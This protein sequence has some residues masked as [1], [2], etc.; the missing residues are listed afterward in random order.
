[1][2]SRRVFSFNGRSLPSLPGLT[3]GAAS[4]A[5]SEA[6]LVR[7]MRAGQD[8][9]RGSCRN[10]RRCGGSVHGVGCRRDSGRFRFGSVSPA[11]GELTRRENLLIDAPGVNAPTSTIADYAVLGDCHGAA[12]V[13]RNGSIDWCSLGRFDADPIFCRILDAGKGGFL[14]VEATGLQETSRTYAGPTNILQTSMRTHSGTVMLTDL[15]PVGRRSGSTNHDYVSLTAPHALI[16]IIECVEG[17]AQVTVRFRPSADFARNAARLELQKG[18]V[19]TNAG[20]DLRSDLSFT[21]DGDVASTTVDLRQGERRVLVLAPQADD[22]FERVDELVRVTTAFWTEWA[23]Y[24][25]YEGPWREQVLRSAL[26]LKLLTYAPTGAIVAA[27]T[28]SLPEEIGGVRNW[29]YRYC[30]LRD[31]SFTLYALAALGYSGE[32]RR[33]MEFTQL[34]CASSHPRVQIMYGIGGE[35]RLDE[36]ELTHLAGYRDSR[37]VRIGNAAFEQD[38]LDVYGEVLDWAW[39]QKKLGQ[40]FSRASRGFFK[41]LADEI[42]ARWRKPDHGIWEERAEPRHYVIGKLVAWAALDRASLMFRGRR[43]F[44]RERDAIRELILREGV[45]SETGALKE[46]LGTDGVDAALLLAPA[47]GFPLDD[48]CLAATI[49]RVQSRL[50]EGGFLRRYESDDGLPGRDGA[51]LACNF[52]LADALLSLDRV[53]DARAAFE[54]AA[55]SANDVGL[56]AEEIDPANGELLG[57]FPQALTHLALINSASNFALHRSHGPAALRGSHADRAAY[58]VEA[59]AGWRALWAVFRKSH[60][61]GRLR[62][63]PHSILREQGAGTGVMPDHGSGN[64]ATPTSAR[65]DS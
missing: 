37:P 62:S 63:S 53:D 36:R 27:V 17:S 19:H 18:R 9:A 26:T 45:D 34:A 56:L 10:S 4:D 29:D 35:A 52:W 7:R 57:N 46:R 14:S 42:I 31:A 60:R 16:R 6:F 41:F 12:L 47:L 3:A 32:A 64:D 40:H 48:Q 58:T 8:Q 21:L 30:W 43:R 51:F 22:A 38:Q 33:F 49:E 61:V 11:A 39:L 55:D 1:M 13:A 50:G 24:C 28:T 65:K 15:M 5:C 59:T 20:A 44:R 2:H 23:E 54:A 25:R